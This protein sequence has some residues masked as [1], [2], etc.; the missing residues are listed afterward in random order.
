MRLTFVCVL[1][2]LEVNCVNSLTQNQPLKP[3][4]CQPVE[5]HINTPEGGSLIPSVTII[6]DGDGY[7][8][9]KWA[10]TFPA[11]TKSMIMLGQWKPN[12]KKGIP[13]GPELEGTGMDGETACD[14]SVITNTKIFKGAD[15]YNAGDYY[16]NI[17]IIDNEIW[18][19]PAGTKAVFASAKRK[20]KPFTTD[21]L[22]TSFDLSARFQLPDCAALAKSTPVPIPTPPSKAET[23]GIARKLMTQM[24][25]QKTAASGHPV[26]MEVS[27]PNNTVLTVTSEA[28]EKY[29]VQAFAN[30]PSF[31]SHF[32][33][34]KFKKII[35]SNGSEA[36]AY[37]L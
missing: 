27:G 32:R 12:P 30:D 7:V 20:V 29:S 19:Q 37:D 1:L 26:S 10:T 9:T 11:G 22:G 33:K 14:G 34:M 8:T 35:F 18:K 24:M 3:G 5:L 36:W 23:E 28:F 25:E 15:G 31:M 4:R 16:A 13:E 17:T 21:E 2:L 6:R